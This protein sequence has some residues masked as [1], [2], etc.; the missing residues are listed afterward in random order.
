MSKNESTD[1]FE[2]MRIQ[3]LSKNRNRG[4][5]VVNLFDYQDMWQYQK[6]QT[7]RYFE[8]KLFQRRTSIV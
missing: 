5:L 6:H 2:N 1:Q 8:R 4:N 3:K 7:K